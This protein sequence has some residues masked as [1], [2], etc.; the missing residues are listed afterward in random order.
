[1]LRFNLAIQSLIFILVL[2]ETILVHYPNG[3]PETKARRITHCINLILVLIYV[4]GFELRQLYKQKLGYF[5][6]PSNIVDNLFLITFV[7][8]VYFDFSAG[9]TEEDSDDYQITLILFAILIKLT[10]IK[11]VTALRIRNSISF[12]VRMLMNVFI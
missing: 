12:I 10:F 3:T 4:L 2:F 8:T 5:K 9:T 7:L 11:L 1:M 6:D